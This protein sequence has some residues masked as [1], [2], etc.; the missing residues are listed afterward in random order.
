MKICGIELTANDAVICLL[1]LDNLQFNLPDC[2]VRKITLP[3]N[4]TCEDLQ[5]FQTTFVK[6]MND[7]GINKVAIKERPPKGRFAG[8][9]IG[10]KLEAALQL[11]ADI[12]VVML[13]Q[14]DI[15][16]GQSENSLP[17]AF[18]ETGLKAFQE[19]AFTVAYVAH[20]L[21]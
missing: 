14:K 13:S 3:K 9:A 2:R 21:R 10:F 1:E 7:Y 17:V 4:H 18:A 15:K 8:G 6:L 11:M 16:L 5:Y 12:D 20:V 19:T